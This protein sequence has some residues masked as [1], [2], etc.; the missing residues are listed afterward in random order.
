MTDS[1]K[2]L[3]GAVVVVAVAA[4]AMLLVE[5]GDSATG[6]GAA[7]VSP[8]ASG[9]ASRETELA[10]ASPGAE[11]SLGA[12]KAS[13]PSA[14]QAEVAAPE[15]AVTSLAMSE[16]PAEGTISGRVVDPGGRPVEG[17]RIV[18]HGDDEARFLR[19]F[20]APD[21]APSPEPETTSG[22]DGRFALTVPVADDAASDDDR[23]FFNMGGSRIVATHEAFAV[24]VHDAAS[25]EESG[26]DVNVGTLS[27]ATGST[28]E[29]RVVDSGGR[30]V[31]EAKV[32]V[33]S[34]SADP[35]GEQSMLALFGGQLANQYTTATTTAEGR[36]RISGVRPGPVAVHAEAEG[37]QVAQ[38]DDLQTEPSLTLSAS[39]LVMET[40]ASI[41]GW[42]VDGDGQPVEGA[43]VRVSSVSR[44]V[45]RRMDDMPRHQIGQEARLRAETDAEGHF[46]LNGLG[47]GQYS[48]HA[49]ADGYA[50]GTLDNVPAGTS[51]L[52]VSLDK[53]GGLLLSLRSALDDSMVDGATVL[54]EPAPEPGAFMM[55]GGGE[56]LDVLLGQEAIDGSG[57]DTDPMGMYFVSGAGSSGL[58]LRIR[59]QGFAAVT[60]VTPSI[61]P[62]SVV[63]FDVLLRPESVISGIVAD[64]T[65]M[66]VSG[67]TVRLAEFVAP[68]SGHG[69]QFEIRREIRRGLGGSGDSGDAWKSAL[70][71][72]SGAYVLRGIPQGDWELTASAE[73]FA[74]DEP[75]MV[76][77]TEGQSLHDVAVKLL[78]AGS[79]AGMVV[80]QDGTPVKGA[81]VTISPVA[82]ASSAALDPM[83]ARLA[84]LMGNDESQRA[85]SDSDGQ[86][87]VPDLLPGLYDVKL[88]KEQGMRMGGAMM[89]V[90]DGSDTSADEGQ[91]VE[92]IAREAAWV[93]LVKP[94]T[95]SLTGRVL[96]GGRPMPGVSVEM[97]EAGS[98][99]P[100][101]G[102]SAVTDDDGRYLFDDVE[103]GDYDISG[104]VSGAALP[105]ERSVKLR[106]GQETQQDLLFAGSTVSGRLVDRET[107]EGVA[108]ATINLTSDAEATSG[109]ATESVMTM[110][111]VSA[112]P[113]GAES[114]MTMDLGGGDL[115]QVRT[116]SNGDFRVEW[117][118]PGTYGIE[119]QGG[120]Y[121]TAQA[122]PFE[123][124]EGHDEDDIVIK[125]DRGA[126]LSGRVVS[127][128]SGQFLDGVPVR[129]ASLDGSESQMS[130][131][132][133]GRYSFDG[134]GA[135]EY[136]VSV[137]GS[138]FGSAPLASEEVTLVKGE[139]HT[140][141]LTT[142]GEAVA[143]GGGG[144]MSITI[145]G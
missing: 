95:S 49:S 127:G 117:V 129:L 2:L 135:G 128:Q 126:S 72:E 90:M 71:D 24:L 78:V 125:A 51:D 76:A 65:G 111:F 118:K 142:T 137:M 144:G 12:L 28:V 22:R 104:I 59:A 123:V 81:Q 37:Y 26:E 91:R 79:L 138:G 30:P 16:A 107:G 35:Q 70:S 53:L 20:G 32:V 56:D 48:V 96:A 25:P 54:A 145:G 119:T 75:V 100:F 109:G 93:E 85:R 60:V 57:V 73:G 50:R 58:E 120:G 13:A 18:Y 11:D 121:I 141:D 132:V 98:F 8:S 7:T 10:E 106:G 67:A 5:D 1:S 44:L 77:L 46:V 61:A 112:G 143:P 87:E 36:Y 82:P 108:G 101:G 130:S 110:A 52:S 92:V 74:A 102:R 114:S 131:T 122:G 9:E 94:L 69:G 63:E 47:L 124:T 43:S 105:E 83:Q 45:I 15:T 113:G 38:L 4:G 17:A 136:T 14:L 19:R 116:S 21:D 140:R 139:P 62:G 23:P 27:M 29:G 86:F 39:D 41:A 84:S 68:P 80:E 99:M 34:L 31:S 66:P 42:V 55:R 33:Q 115:S 6:G 64:S 133:E 97:K 3:L 40:G 134:L 88:V 103:P 89:I